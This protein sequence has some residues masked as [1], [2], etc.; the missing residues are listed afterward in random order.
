VYKQETTVSD[1]NENSLI[2][3]SINLLY[4][5]MIVQDDI[6]DADGDRLLIRSGNMLNDD[7][8][9]RIRSLNSG[10]STIYV[11]GRT[12][13][14]MVTKRPNIEIESQSEVEK[15][16]GYTETKNITF[17]ILEEIAKNKVVNQESLKDVSSEL[18]KR[19]KST[20][21][22]VIISLINAM[23]PVDEYLPRHSVNVSLLNGLLGRWIGLPEDNV[24]KLV[25]IGL[26]HDCG[27]TQLPSRV[28]NAPR[29]LTVVE[30]EVIKMHA[31]FTFDLLSEFAQDVR[32]AA[33]S[34]H[35]R[36]DGSGYPRGLSKDEIAI[37][38]RISA[39]SDIYDAMV[40][41]RAYKGPA[42]P[43]SI[44]AFLEKLSIRQLDSELVNVFKEFM[45]K[46]LIN[47]PVM[48]SDGTIGVVREVDPEDIEYPMV[49]HGGY[50]IKT[51][52]ELYCVSM[53]S[54]D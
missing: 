22:G 28:L 44:M 32:L 50:L 3:V 40:S 11:T 38:A 26:L 31:V 13:H 54:D 4:D 46:E 27:K 12:H 49:D 42:S 19:L 37:E 9:E 23:A 8:I 18:S 6:Y 7:Q 21:P 10:R 14:F 39:I 47:K 35:E 52:E 41:Q 30:F 34:H 16:F 5:G 20:P 45:P 17:E 24:D 53:Y 36:L 29:K 48:M 25:L 1:I 33:S 51:S 43:F 15:A 2:P